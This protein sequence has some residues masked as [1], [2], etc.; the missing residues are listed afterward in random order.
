ML[1]ALAMKKVWQNR[2]KREGKP[3]QAVLVPTMT[4]AATAETVIHMGAFPVLVDC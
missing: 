2:R 3:M 1:G 4:F